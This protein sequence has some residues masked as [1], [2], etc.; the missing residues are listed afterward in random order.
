MTRLI[1]ADKL[2]FHECADSDC[3]EASKENCAVC[4]FRCVT[5]EEIDNAPT[6]EPNWKFYFDHGY[7]QAKKDLKMALDKQ[8]NFEENCRD[9]V[10]EII[11]NATPVCGNNPKWCES[12]VSKG[13]CASTRP[14]GGFDYKVINRGK[15]ILCGKEVTEG[16]FF[17]KECEEKRKSKEE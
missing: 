12:C 11:D 1:D 7:A 6:V 15:C 3:I 4:E 10:F 8:M 9:S 5:K 2:P 16:L 14:Q 13:K 17:C